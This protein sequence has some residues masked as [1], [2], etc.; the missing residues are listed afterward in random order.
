MRMHP[1]QRTELL[2]GRD[3]WTRLQGAS[4]C[5][6][7][8]GGIGS[9]AAEALVRAGVGHVTL[10]DFDDVCVTNLNR[11]LHALRS[12]IGQSKA[13]LMA[14]R[15]RDIN[16]KADIRALPLFYAADTSAQI[17]DRRYDF[18][19]DAIDNMATKVHLLETCY[20]AGQPVIAAMGAGG[21]LDPTRIRVTD[22]AKTRNDP[23][24]RIVRDNLRQRGIHQGIT[25]VWTDEPPNELDAEVQAGFRC[26]CPDKEN[27]P[28]SCDKKFQVQGTVSWMPSM[29]GL[30]L[31]G[32]V[33]NALLGR[34]VERDV[35]KVLPPR[36][37]PAPRPPADRRREL[38]AGARL[39][40]PTLGPPPLSL[41][42]PGD[43]A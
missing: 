2:V 30:T 32:V 34:T 41:D 28:N 27:S 38:L 25:A 8:L 16:P 43:S 21:R 20:A 10:V 24:A 3:G 33:V 1:F 18:V 9:Y 26:I 36:T 19:V 23:L 40:M 17:L 14:T 6:V 29:F 37:P 39:A 12:T 4:V 42:E 31:A 5:V 15:C 35:E 22:L 13:E 7:G 11:Q